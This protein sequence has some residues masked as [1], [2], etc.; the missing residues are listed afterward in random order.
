MLVDRDYTPRLARAF[1]EAATAGAD[2]D[3]FLV[4]EVVELE[5]DSRR[6]VSDRR[7]RARLRATEVPQSVVE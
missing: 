5:Q 3:H 2:D 7:D 6:S 4:R 1:G